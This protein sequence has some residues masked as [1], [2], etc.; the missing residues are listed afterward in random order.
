MPLLQLNW[1][2]D[3]IIN[4]GRRKIMGSI[5]NCM[6]IMVFGL[7]VIGC[8]N[9][10][11][12]EIDARL[13][14]KWIAY[15]E[16]TIN[17]PVEHLPPDYINQ[18]PD[19]YINEETGMA[20]VEREY[21]MELEF[22]NGLYEYSNSSKGTYSTNN[23]KITMKTTHVYS[24]TILFDLSNINVINQGW[25]TKDELKTL[26]KSI[27]LGEVEYFSDEEI[28]NM[29]SEQIFNYSVNGNTLLFNSNGEIITFTRE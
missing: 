13:N 8:E 29:F 16:I 3:I 11:K 28:N 26:P 5:K 10:I 9:D 1:N 24:G 17:I 18:F 27:S 25:Y 20:E 14:G 2:C 6:K 19:L 4:E 15:I 22:N 23:G 7:L 12:D 21:K